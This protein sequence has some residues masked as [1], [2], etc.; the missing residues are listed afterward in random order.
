MWLKLAPY[1]IL[2]E[3]KGW[4]E[5]VTKGRYLHKGKYRLLELHTISFLSPLE[6]QQQKDIYGV[7]WKCIKAAYPSQSRK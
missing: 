4:V 6:Q 5:L 7:F 3:Y 2:D 1:V